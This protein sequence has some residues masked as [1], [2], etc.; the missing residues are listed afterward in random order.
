MLE[1]R[2]LLFSLKFCVFF[3]QL[4]LSSLLINSVRSLAI[5][6]KSLSIHIFTS[7]AIRGFIVPGSDSIV[8]WNTKFNL[9]FQIN[10]FFGNIYDSISSGLW[11][12][13]RNYVIIK[14][15]QYFGVAVIWKQNTKKSACRKG[16]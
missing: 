10:I 9:Q 16:D 3:L 2:S 15:S 5:P 13:V 8:K 6:F 12:S 14:R 11:I 7:L 1:F 4:F